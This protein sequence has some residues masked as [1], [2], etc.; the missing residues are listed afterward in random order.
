VG[1]AAELYGLVK[2]TDLN[3]NVCT[4][5]QYHC[6]EERWEVDVVVRDAP[7]RKVR[8]AAI[9]LRRDRI[10]VNATQEVFRSRWPDPTDADTS[11][12]TVYTH[13]LAN[14][15]PGIR[16]EMLILICIDGADSRVFV[17]PVLLNI[18]P[19]SLAFWDEALLLQLLGDKLPAH[20][21]AKPIPVA[22]DSP[23]FLCMFINAIQEVHMEI[24]SNASVVY[25]ATR[26]RSNSDR[27]ALVTNTACA[28]PAVHCKSV[29][30]TT[31]CVAFHKDDFIRLSTDLSYADAVRQ[32]VNMCTNKEDLC[33]ICCEDVRV[34]RGM[35]I[36]CQCK[37]KIHAA[38]FVKL[39]D[40][41]GRSCPVCRLPFDCGA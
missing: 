8:V 19:T 33:P 11:A 16:K 27:F 22:W 31:D 28:I 15:T 30:T 18:P 2:H 34:E 39:V 6:K 20:I 3:G 24:Q 29:A 26:T 7:L 4:L 21:Q 12:L 37:A 10:I 5:V 35:S 32:I 25:I 14:S 38:C 9:R 41:L 23:Q 36:P 40:K 1:Y 13:L 17:P